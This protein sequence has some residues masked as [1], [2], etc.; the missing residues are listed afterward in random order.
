[1][2]KKDTDSHSHGTEQPKSASNFSSSTRHSFTA[3]VPDQWPKQQKQAISVHGWFYCYHLALTVLHKT[4]G[5]GQAWLPSLLPSLW[6]PL[7]TSPPPE[8]HGRP[9]A[10]NPDRHSGQTLRSCRVLHTVHTGTSERVV[11]FSFGRAAECHHVSA[12]KQNPT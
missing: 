7:G 8:D 1:M 10:L 11:Y 2:S 4:P 5:R 6:A 12:S 3:K 9:A